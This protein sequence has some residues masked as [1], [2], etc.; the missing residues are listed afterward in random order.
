MNLTRRDI[1]KVG[2]SAL[3]GATLGKWFGTEQSALKKTPVVGKGDF[4]YEVH[5]D[6]LKPPMNIAWGDTH[7]V[8]QDRMGRIYIAHTVH[9]SS[10][11]RDAVVVFDEN[12]KFIESWGEDFAGGAHGLD[13][14]YEGGVGFLY[15][16][17]TRRR[18]VVKTTLGG[19]KV[20]ERGMPSEAGVYSDPG[21][22][23]PTNVAFAPNGDLFVGDGYGSSYVH[24]Y[25]K[26]GAYVGVVC[27]PGSGAGQVSCPHGLWV[28]ERGSEPYLVVADRSNHRLQYLTLEG[29]HVKFITDG[30][31]MPCH[32]HFNDGKMLVPDLTS[33]VT[34][35]GESNEVLAQLCDGDPSGLR[36]AP[37]E[38]FVPGKFIH[39]HAAAWVNGDDILVVEWVPIGRVTLLKKV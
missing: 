35:L 6:W 3:A 16:C 25:T 23:C 38:Q 29:K 31:R 11:K 15:H 5:H 34:I 4:V 37:R 19:E 33:V 10:V 2:A 24:R 22:W 20:W 14:R 32:L 28:D 1:L 36:G 7:G 30:M 27:G 13:L 39:P 8:A 18:L 26:D 17:D 21:Q 9:P 12:G